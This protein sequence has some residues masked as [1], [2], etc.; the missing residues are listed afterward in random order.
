MPWE[1]SIRRGRRRWTCQ[2]GVKQ[3]LSTVLLGRH[4]RFPV[5]RAGFEPA[6]TASE[7]VAHPLSYR[8]VHHVLPVGLEPT[9]ST[10]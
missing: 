4:G 5:S 7:A 3:A 1:P 6:S 2:E 8:D 10:T 9:L